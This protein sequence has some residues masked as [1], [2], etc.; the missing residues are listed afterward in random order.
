M[1]VSDFHF[2]FSLL[3][4]ADPMEK[5]CWGPVFCH[6]LGFDGSTQKWH[7]LVESGSLLLFYEEVSM[8][9]W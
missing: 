6:T 4:V 7:Y 9:A 8:I 2:W 5:P 1:C 3:Q